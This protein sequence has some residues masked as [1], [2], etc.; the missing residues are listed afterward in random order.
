M[1]SKKRPEESSDAR[2]ARLDAYCRETYRLSLT[3]FLRIVSWP[4]RRRD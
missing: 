4:S 3:E 1:A 2:D